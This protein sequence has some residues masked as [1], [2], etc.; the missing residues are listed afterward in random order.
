M[1]RMH[2][3]RTFRSNRPRLPAAPRAAAGPPC[4]RPLVVH[5][6]NSAAGLAN[7]VLALFGR[8][9]GRYGSLPLA[10]GWTRFRDFPAPQ[11]GGTFHAQ[12]QRRK[13]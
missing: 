2:C 13:A 6:Q 9:D 3:P 12:W 10:G 7:R 8:A 11:P 5:E 1:T 4:R